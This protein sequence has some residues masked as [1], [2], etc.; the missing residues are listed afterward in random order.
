MIDFWSY[1]IQSN[2]NVYPG[3]AFDCPQNRTL[4]TMGVSSVTG[5]LIDAIMGIG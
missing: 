5:T 1:I 4:T 2:V 3:Y